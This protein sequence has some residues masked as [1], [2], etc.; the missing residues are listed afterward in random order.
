MLRKSNSQPRN[1]QLAK[2]S[3][4]EQEENKMSAK[5]RLSPQCLNVKFFY[6]RKGFKNIKINTHICPCFFN[7]Y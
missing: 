2:L 7:N 1:L 4:N 6:Q 3:K 5:S